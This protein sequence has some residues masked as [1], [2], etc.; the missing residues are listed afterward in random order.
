MGT[1]FIVKPA[2]ISIRR[3]AK[4]SR[5]VDQPDHIIVNTIMSYQAERRPAP[6]EIWLAVTQHDGVQVDS[7][8]IDQAKF[9][10]ALRQA[11]AGNFDL[12]VALGLQR[13][14]RAFKIILNKPGVGADRFQRARHDP[15]RL[16]P[17][18]RREG[19]FSV[20]HSG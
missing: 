4:L 20:S 1:A 16:I 6:G 18:C 8:L 19:V 15:F 10:Q 3:V 11:R 13:A 5:N 17:P 9:G 2:A 14:D 12:S 7:I